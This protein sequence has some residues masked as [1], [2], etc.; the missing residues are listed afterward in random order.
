MSYPLSLRAQATAP[1]GPAGADRGRDLPVRTPPGPRFG[2]SGA[3]TALHGPCG[4][5]PLGAA[6][7]TFD[8]RS[9]VTR[10][11]TV[12][13]FVFHCLSSAFDLLCIGAAVHGVCLD[14]ASGWVEVRARRLIAC[15]TLTRHARRGWQCQ[16]SR[17]SPPPPGASTPLRAQPG[18]RRRPAC[19]MPPAPRW[20]AAG[21]RQPRY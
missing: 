13:R 10:C 18:A 16:A 4:A 20:R 19:G 14:P 5:E 12:V 21:A 11:V 8:G 15:P 3:D 6:A 9:C 7:S 1:H 17:P 2:P